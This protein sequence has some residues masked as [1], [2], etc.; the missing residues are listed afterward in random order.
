LLEFTNPPAA[1]T[2]LNIRHNVQT[3]VIFVKE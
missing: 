1:I 2:E 3:S